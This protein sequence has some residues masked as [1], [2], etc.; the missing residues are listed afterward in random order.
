MKIVYI[1]NARIPTE[2]AHGYTICKMCAEFARAGNTVELIIPSRDNSITADLFDFYGLEK[3]F[4]VKK[5]PTHDF[6]N[7]RQ[8]Y[9]IFVYFLETINFLWHLL[10]L[11]FDPDS[12]IY[13]RNT[14]IAWLMK[15]KKAMSSMN[16]IIGRRKRRYLKY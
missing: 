13:T 6:I 5:L 14:E 11:K 4:A 12:I 9:G 3:N 8:H 7:G 2:K 1:A 16:A 15:L 10:F